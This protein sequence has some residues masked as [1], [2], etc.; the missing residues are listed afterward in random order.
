[1]SDILEVFYVSFDLHAHKQIV[2]IIMYYDD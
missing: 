2:L 1:M